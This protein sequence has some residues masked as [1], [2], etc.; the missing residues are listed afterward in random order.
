MCECEPYA[1]YMNTVRGKVRPKPQDIFVCGSGSRC[2]KAA[3][4][5]PAPQFVNQAWNSCG[6][7]KRDIVY[8]CACVYCNYACVNEKKRT[9]Q[10]YILS[11]VLMESACHHRSSKTGGWEWCNLWNAEGWQEEG[12]RK[13]RR[14]GCWDFLMTFAFFGNVLMMPYS[15]YLSER[16]PWWWVGQLSEAQCVFNLPF[17]DSIHSKVKSS[18]TYNDLTH[19]LP[20]DL[21]DRWEYL[22]SVFRLRLSPVGVDIVLINI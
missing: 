1:F 8:V 10:G 7:L 4:E 13:K 9:A 6:S 12:N 16:L 3:G 18:L 2:R 11:P 14:R 22:R 21:S 19:P 17:L 20:S 15:N 5:I